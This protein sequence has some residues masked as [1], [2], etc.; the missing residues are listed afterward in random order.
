MT[1][2]VEYPCPLCDDPGPHQVLDG[3]GVARIVLCEA[4]GREVTLVVKE[5][6][7]QS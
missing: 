2:T 6:T 7:T 4:C 1:A 3:V 5:R